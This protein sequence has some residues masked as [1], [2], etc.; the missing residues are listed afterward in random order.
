MTILIALTFFSL[1]LASF[2]KQIEK[3]RQ[4]LHKQSKE[5]HYL[6]NKDPLTDALNSVDHYI[7]GK[8]LLKQ[9]KMQKSELSMLCIFIDNLPSI[10]QK[11][12]SQVEVALLAHVENLMNEQ[13]QNKGNITKVNQEEFCILLPEFDIIS[14]KSIGQHITNSIQQN[15]FS[16]RDTK[17]PLTLSIGVSNLLENDNEIRSIQIRADKALNKAKKLGGNRIFTHTM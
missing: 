4:K 14:A 9:A 5:L 13:L 7:L 1:N 2:T 12:G 6:A 8:S 11:H 15:L 3:Y 16:A 17:I 10:Y